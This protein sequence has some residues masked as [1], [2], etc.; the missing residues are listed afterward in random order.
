MHMIIFTGTINLNFNATKCNLWYFTVWCKRCKNIAI[1]YVEP[2]S[3]AFHL[4]PCSLASVSDMSVRLCLSGPR[5]HKSADMM[6]TCWQTAPVN[7]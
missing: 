1:D 3:S 4:L 2:V 6:D 5:S 7:F